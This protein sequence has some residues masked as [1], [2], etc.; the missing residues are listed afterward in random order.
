MELGIAAID[1]VARE[2]MLFAAAG[3]LLGGLDDLAVDLLWIV[4]RV[5][6]RFAPDPLLADLPRP[7]APMRFAVFVAAWGEE[8]V[9]GPMLRTA[10]DRIDHPAYRIFVGTYPNDPATIA[11][12]RAVVRTDPRVRLVIGPRDGPTTKGDNLNVLWRALL[13]EDE[14]AGRSTDA[15]VVHDAE[16]VIHPDELT[17]HEVALADA[18]VSQTPVIPLIDD[19]TLA[20]QFVSGVYAD[21]F[22][23]NHRASLVVR[24]AIG[25]GLPLAGV[26]CAVR[27]DA[28]RRLG[29]A[30]G[31]P[32]EA[33]SLTEDY[34]QGLRLSALGC[35]ARFI[36]VRGAGGSLVAT[37]A[38]FPAHF[39]AS[40]SQKA[41][42]MT[43]IALA[44][45][46]RIGW[47]RPLAMS[48]HW[49]RMRDRRAP[50]ATLVTAAGYLAVLLVTVSFGLHAAAGTSVPSVGA[51]MRWLLRI[52]LALLAWRIAMRVLHT[53]RVYGVEEGVWALPRMVV[54][55]AVAAVA[56]CRALARYVRVL[57]GGV[58]RWEKTEHVF[59]DL[60]ARE[61]VV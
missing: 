26:G 59:P 16:D 29:A 14:R 44:G 21:E 30:A 61:P 5:R 9:I 20:T 33:V 38:Y 39:A 19:S 22:A 23:A 11:E 3:F 47:A 45:W 15:V 31:E 53:M 54:G 37:R 55:N 17:A 51:A 4:G 41:R 25:A 7:P 35:R 18:A 10:L 40:T 13:D 42:W 27:T 2:L 6:A 49:M 12:V 1:A 24:V 28:L 56:I 60:S 8:R 36:R 46:D 34:E 52:D 32:F 58:Q 57:R 48:E 50:L 43:G